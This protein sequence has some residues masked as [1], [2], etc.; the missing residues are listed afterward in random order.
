VVRSISKVP[1]CKPVWH[2]YTVLIDFERLGMDR[3]TLMKRLK[4][5]GIGTQVHYI[6]V[7]R[8]PYYHNRYG[9]TELPGAEQYYERCLSLPLFPGMDD[10]DVVR[11]AS[12]L[13]TLLELN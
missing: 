13:K 11:V 9:V 7:H 6:P 10:E 12:S 3:A 2:L 4:D 8:Q 1:D 5:G